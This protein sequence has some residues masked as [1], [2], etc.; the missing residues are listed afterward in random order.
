M[1]TRIL[2][3]AF[4]GAVIYFLLGWLVY[5]NLIVD[6]FAAHSMHYEGLEKMPPNLIG[7]FVSGFS[8]CLLLAV[9]FG[10]W[11]NINTL[12]NG[13]MA[14][15]AIGILVGLYVDLSLYSTLNLYGR[16]VVVV[17]VLLNALFGAI[18]GAVIAWIL[19]YRKNA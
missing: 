7:I 14:G 17:D 18:L 13:A 16:Q 4:A 6:F 1:N 5:G 8:F 11:A 10:N 12:K 3:A 19:G 2:I 9:I 15:T